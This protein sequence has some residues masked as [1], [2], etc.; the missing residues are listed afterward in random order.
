MGTDIIRLDLPATHKYLHLASACVGEMLGR[1]EGIHDLEQ[2]CYNIQLAVQ[3]GCSNIVDHAYSDDQGRIDITFT[4]K[5]APRCLVVELCDVG[6][7]F[8]P[9]TVQDPDLDMPQ[10]RGYGMFIMRALMDEVAYDVR[11]GT[12]CLRMVKAL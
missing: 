10:V 2:T 6:Q 8:N 4:L 7:S 9:D 1:I 11:A 5:E 12:N 3:E